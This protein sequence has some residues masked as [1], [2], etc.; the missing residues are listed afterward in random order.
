MVAFMDL[1]KHTKN[2]KPFLLTLV[3]ILADQLS[4]YLVV[5]QIPLRTIAYSV[6]NDFFRLIHVRNTGVAFSMGDNL[7][8][9]LRHALF[10]LLP[11]FVLIF[12]AVHIVRSREETVF[13]KFCLAGILGGGFGNLIDR[14]FRTEGVVDFLDVRFYGLFGLER[15]PTFNIA[16][17]SVVVCGILL[18]ISFWGK[19]NDKKG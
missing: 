3:L 11:L 15:W 7:P 10:I 9:Q 2:W 18:F 16:D 13:Q 8:L 19:E 17:A 4:K 14:I 1:E 12:L 5:S 6:G